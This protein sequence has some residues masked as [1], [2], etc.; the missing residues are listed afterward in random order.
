MK[1]VFKKDYRTDKKIYRPISI[2]SNV[3]KIYERHLNKQLEEF[4]QVLLPKYRNKHL[5][6]SDWKMEKNFSTKV[7]PLEL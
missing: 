7:A 1:V 6:P 2:L 4:F 3:S 5:D